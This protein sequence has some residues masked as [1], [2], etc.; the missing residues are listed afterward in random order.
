MSNLVQFGPSHLFSGT[1]FFIQNGYLAFALP[2]LFSAIPVAARLVPHYRPSRGKLV[3]RSHTGRAYWRLLGLCSGTGVGVAIDIE[4]SR[5]VH[6][7]IN[8]G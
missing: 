7:R 6:R 4:K 3:F 1:K 5:R 2:L 8:L